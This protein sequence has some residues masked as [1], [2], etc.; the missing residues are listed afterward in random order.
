MKCKR[1]KKS[2]DHCQGSQEEMYAPSKTGKLIAYISARMCKTCQY[3]VQCY[4]KQ[5]DRHVGK[6]NHLQI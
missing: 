4:V 1:N 6:F 3:N 2:E 5:S